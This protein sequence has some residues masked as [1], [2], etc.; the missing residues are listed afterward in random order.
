MIPKA[1]V[2]L[3]TDIVKLF[4]GRMFCNVVFEVVISGHDANSS[5]SNVDGN[6][7]V[8]SSSILLYQIK[9]DFGLISSAMQKKT[10]DNKSL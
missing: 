10:N 1:Q 4:L 8:T 7:V 6:G 2:L 3:K 9:L 5:S